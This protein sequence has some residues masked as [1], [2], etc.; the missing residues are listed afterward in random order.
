M[1]S[2]RGSSIVH[3]H[4]TAQPAAK[5]RFG[6]TL[7][8]SVYPPW[9]DKY[10]DYAKLKS[11]LR[12]DKYDDDEVPWTEDDE[13]R[14]CDEIFNVQ[15]DKVARFQEE[16]V[17]G[18]R[19]RVDAAFDR[20]R[21]LAPPPPADDDGKAGGA[22]PGGEIT[23]ARLK[24]V[25]AE[26]DGITNDV[27]ELK[28]YSN[29]NYTGFLKIVKKHDRKRGDR[30]KVRPMMQLSLS[31]RPFNSEQGYAPLLNKLSLMYFA[32]RQHI[33]DPAHA[34]D[35]TP[36][37]LENQ[38]ET[39][40]GERYTALKCKLSLKYC[41]LIQTYARQFGSIRTT[42]SRS[43]PTS[44]AGCPPSSTPRPRTPRTSRATMTRPSRR[45]TLTAPS[46]TSTLK[47]W[48]S[49]QRRRRCACL[50]VHILQI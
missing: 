13:N 50:R 33:E 37:D 25:E 44:C 3:D 40:D 28:K 35:Q 46:S 14:F 34:L 30:Y 38:G 22:K 15:L 11:L 48:T 47:R 17:T 43:R 1:P 8:E 23:L 31:K 42:C 16:T 6:K 24:E 4:K 49:R 18:L 2:D 7:R 27:R 45:S 29:I 19:A 39:R 32:I 36:L 9:K 26:L 20:L 12:E 41:R 5:M 10:I 21:D